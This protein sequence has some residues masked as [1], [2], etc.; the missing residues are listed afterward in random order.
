MSED[1]PH[2][3]VRSNKLLSKIPNPEVLR[4]KPDLYLIQK[5]DAV[6]ARGRQEYLPAMVN[7]VERLVRLLR[8]QGEPARCG[9]SR[10]T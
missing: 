2:I 9:R 8:E 1:D 7:D 6:V 4:A 5:L 10:T 3:E